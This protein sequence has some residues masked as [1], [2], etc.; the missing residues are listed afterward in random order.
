MSLNLDA[1]KTFVFISLNTFFVLSS[2]Q[3]RYAL[4]VNFGGGLKWEYAD[5]VL[6]GVPWFHSEKVDD[7][8]QFVVG[9]V[10]HLPSD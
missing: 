5:E 3:P 7:S 1:E 6:R 10:Y 8:A 9:R 4:I 2:G